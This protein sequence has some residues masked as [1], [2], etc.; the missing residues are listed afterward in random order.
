MA[1]LTARELTAMPAPIDPFYAIEIS[2]IAGRLAAEGREIIHME[3]GQPQAG[4][5]QAA[6]EAARQALDSSV[7]G[8]WQSPSLK[9][10]LSQHYREQYGA[11]VAP[12]RIFLTCGA[13]PALVLALVSAFSPGDRVALARPGYVAYR[14]TLRGL[15]MVAEELPCG[16]ESR[17][18]ITAETVA[19]LD[20]PPAGLIIASPSN[21]TGTIIPPAELARIAE[22]SAARGITVISDEIYH[23]LTYTHPT[24]TMLNFS[25]DALVV[26][27][28][29]KYFCMPGW[30]MGWLV[31]P[32]GLKAQASAYIGNFFLTSPSLSQ[33]AALAALDAR[34]ELDRHIGTYAR[35]REI[36]L[37]ALPRLGL[38]EIAPPDGAFYIYANVERVTE[39]SFELCKQLLDETGVVIAPGRDFDPVNGHRFVRFSFAVETETVEAALERLRVWFASQ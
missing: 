35:N 15:H 26:N 23:G 24:Q 29:S 2:Q 32:E 4:A 36:L 7:P 16:P 6:L 10:R 21:P 33:T 37:D 18:Q 22:V 14:N 8:Y 17:F 27:S 25:G 28:F 3:F 5:P 20:P 30:R 31:A 12:E 1:A 38:S 13:S 34:E 11:E 19:A 39:D 9:A